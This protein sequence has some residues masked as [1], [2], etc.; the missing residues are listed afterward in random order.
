[1][2]T[3][4]REKTL[5]EARRLIRKA[6]PAIE[7]SRKWAKPTNPEGVPAWSRAGL[8]CTG[9]T[10]REV[11]K[12]TFARG[13]FLEDPDGLFNASLDG[14]LRRAIDLR[15]GEALPAAAFTRLVRAAVAENLRVEAART[16]RRRGA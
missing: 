9:E 11:V 8:V 4:W 16:P 7:E 10:Y 15:E 12:L 5:A 2:A 14:N 3:D 13:A 6:D 1:M